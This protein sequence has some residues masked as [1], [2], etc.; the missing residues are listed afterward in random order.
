[1]DAD[2]R[3]ADVAG[4]ATILT[5]NDAMQ[6]DAD[7]IVIPASCASF[8]IHLTHVGTLPIGAMG[9]NVVIA[10]AADMPAIVADGMAATPRHIKPGD[11]RVIA[12]TDMIGGGGSTSVTFDVALVREG[13]PYRFFCSFPGHLARMQG[14]LQVQ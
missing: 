10:R 9:H 6:F 11:T 2:S 3:A 14:S 12:H 1:M 4:C 7:A 8:T 5:S 13:G